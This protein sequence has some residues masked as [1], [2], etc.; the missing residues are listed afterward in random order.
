ML[1]MMFGQG[2]VMVLLIVTA[3]VVFF[4]ARGR[5]RR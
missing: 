4:A 1:G 2:E 3:V 5:N